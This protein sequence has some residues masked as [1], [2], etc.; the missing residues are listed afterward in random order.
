MKS[1]YTDEE[2]WP[3]RPVSSNS[4]EAGKPSQTDVC[5]NSKSEVASCNRGRSCEGED[6]EECNDS[7][8]P[9]DSNVWMP[10]YDPA[11][12]QS[13]TDHNTQGETLPPIT[14]S[15]IRQALGT[16]DSFLREDYSDASDC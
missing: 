6:P 11:F 13:C 7:D 10:Y 12:Y 4:T 9:G 1:R 8:L 14:H 16:P 15:L 3:D 5:L 2:N